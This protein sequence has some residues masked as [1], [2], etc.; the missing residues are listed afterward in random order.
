MLYSNIKKGWAI[1]DGNM[2]F[3]ASEGIHVINWRTFLTQQ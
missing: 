2:E 1:Y 3:D